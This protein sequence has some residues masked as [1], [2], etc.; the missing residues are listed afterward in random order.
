MLLLIDIS[1]LFYIVYSIDI[2]TKVIKNKNP[3]VGSI[4]ACGYFKHNPKS[5]E[6]NIWKDETIVQKLH[7]SWFLFVSGDAS[8]NFWETSWVL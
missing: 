6:Y 1:P 3:L 2:V 8:L 5:Q 4:S 7:M